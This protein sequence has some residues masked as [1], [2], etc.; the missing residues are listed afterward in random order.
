MMSALAGCGGGE[1]TGR[2]GQQ[3]THDTPSAAAPP[4]VGPEQRVIAVLETAAPGAGGQ[5]VTLEQGNGLVLEGPYDGAPLSQ[6]APLFAGG[7]IFVISKIGKLTALDLAGTTLFGVPEQGQLG[8]TSPL[9]AGSDDWVRVG[10]T[11]GM[12]LAF[13]SS[14]G[15]ERMRAEA[16][17]A[18]TTPLAVASDGTTYA[19][20]DTGRVVGVSKTSVIVFDQQV[21][22][23]ASGPS[24]LSSGDIAVGE[25]SGLRIFSPQ[26][27]ERLKHSRAARVVGTRA[28]EDGGLLAW[29]EDGVVERLSA[30][31]TV[32]LRYV[33]AASSPPPVYA[34]PKPIGDR[35]A[36]IDSSGVVHLVDTDGTAMATLELGA[37]PL[38]EV[39]EG[40]GNQLLITLGST[41][42]GLG[43]TI[44]EE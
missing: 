11:S 9:T 20:T 34:T 35:L 18:I 30:D 24:V 37:E 38:R 43:F 42:R 27:A 21:D 16:G 40:E 22:P 25:A 28:L 19:A 41:I 6:H 10:T 31:G 39:A 33:T 23:P 7:K 14:D 15:S 32:E 3:W 17:G 36:L 5:L 13:D 1:I 2:I 26:G 44:V 8:P 29:G 12:V 4:G